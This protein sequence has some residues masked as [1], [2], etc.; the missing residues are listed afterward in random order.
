LIGKKSE[1]NYHS[2]GSLKTHQK[3]P[4]T[5][6]FF[7]DNEDLNATFN[8]KIMDFLTDNQLKRK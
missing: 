6:K 4:K 8:C 1:E 3:S 5:G 7:E 2:K